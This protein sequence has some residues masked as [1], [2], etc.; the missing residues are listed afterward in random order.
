MNDCVSVGKEA[1]SGFPRLSIDLDAIAANTR[2]LAARLLVNGFSLVGVTKALDGEPSAGRE[3][4]EAGCAGLADSRLSSLRRLAEHGLAP[5][6][7]VRA[8][9][10]T[11]SG[12]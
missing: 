10:I 12:P 9:L 8:P 11:P 2:Q 5:L 1:G 4:L 6:T 7:L 3:M